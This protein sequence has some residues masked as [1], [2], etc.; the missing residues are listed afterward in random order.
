MLGLVRRREGD[1][2]ASPL[3]HVRNWYH[4]GLSRSLWLKLRLSAQAIF[5]RGPKY[6]C[7]SGP[8]YMC[9]SVLGTDGS[10]RDPEML[11]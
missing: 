1:S 6:M 8:K 10:G 3:R 7:L 9:L 5:G 4:L 11:C 2:A